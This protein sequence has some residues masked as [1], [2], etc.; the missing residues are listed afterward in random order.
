MV[1]IHRKDGNYIFEV[2]GI[3]KPWSLKSQ[4]TIPAQHIL[5][6]QQDMESIKGWRG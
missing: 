2:N 6:A 5:N 4:L 1:T 3:H